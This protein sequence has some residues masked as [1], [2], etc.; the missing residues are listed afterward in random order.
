MKRDFTF[1]LIASG[2]PKGGIG[3]FSGN[4]V[5]RIYS[6]SKTKCGSCGGNDPKIYPVKK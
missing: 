5:Q 2:F 4:V 3:V 6:T 1:N